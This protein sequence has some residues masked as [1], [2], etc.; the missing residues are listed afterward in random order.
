MLGKDFIDRKIPSRVDELCAKLERVEKRIESMHLASLRDSK[1][2][3]ELND[4]LRK[5]GSELRG[6]SGR[7][8]SLEREFDEFKRRVK[9][10][11]L[12]HAEFTARLYTLIVEGLRKLGIIP[13]DEFHEHM[14][15]LR[16]RIDELL[17]EV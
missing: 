6:L 15:S 10:L 1:K 13:H 17:S 3:V 4:A 16:K 12:L 8:S 14:A 5:L 11:M 9:E 2:L 7:V